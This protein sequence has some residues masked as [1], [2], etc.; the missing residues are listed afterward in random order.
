M[1]FPEKKKS[2]DDLDT[3]MSALEAILEKVNDK[4]DKNHKE[5]KKDVMVAKPSYAS[6][7]REIAKDSTAPTVTVTAAAD[8]NGEKKQEL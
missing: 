6:L 8:N 1:N 5:L 2:E 4:I 7:T 3:R